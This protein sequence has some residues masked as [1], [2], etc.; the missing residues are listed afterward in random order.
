VVVL[1]FAIQFAW[2]FLELNQFMAT[3]RSYLAIAEWLNRELPPDSTVLSFSLTPILKHESSLK[4]KD[5]FFETP[6]SLGPLLQGAH[7]YLLLDVPSVETQW[8]GRAPALNYEY[9]RDRVG[10]EAIGSRMTFTL[11]RIKH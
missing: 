10:L 4:Y 11:Y 8:A 3:T 5:I 6:E 7:N 1:V 2:G 9:L